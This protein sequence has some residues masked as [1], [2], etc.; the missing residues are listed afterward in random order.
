MLTAYR[1][2][3]LALLQD[4]APATAGLED[5]LIATRPV[6]VLQGALLQAVLHT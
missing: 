3:L 5:G 6:S 1:H 4:F 2:E